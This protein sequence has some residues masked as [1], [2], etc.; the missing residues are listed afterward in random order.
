M[1]ENYTFGLTS[2]YIISVMSVGTLVM[3]LSVLIPVGY[4]VR[5]KPKKIL[6]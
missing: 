5:L 6:L 2:D 4:I 1:L 3:I